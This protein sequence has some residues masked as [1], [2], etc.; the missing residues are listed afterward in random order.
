VDATQLVRLLAE[1]RAGTVTPEEAAQRIGALPYA[2]V[3]Q[4]V[5]LDH[6]RELRTGIPEMVYGAS[7]TADQIV[8]AM[9]ELVKDGGAIATRVDAAKAA[10][11][12]AALPAA[13]YHEGARVIVLGKPG[14]RPPCATIAV[15]CAGTSDLG[16][17]EECGLVA[18]FLGA[19][20]LRVG[21][22]GVAGLHRLLAR[23]ED[24]RR[25][26][27]VVGVA[28]ME[29]ALP[30]V[31]G[32]LIDKPL[33]AVPT[34]VGYGVSLDGLVALGALLSG[35]VPGT[36]VVNIDN[37]VGAAVAAVKIGRLATR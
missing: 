8:A 35:C 2:E 19:P 18:E 1:V 13:V 10:A 33:I 26:D 30:S 14:P 34:S 27:V 17:A 22:V 31:L 20:V 21:D 37:G 3:A 29:A 11:V 4:A 5:V 28:G 9:R 16:V 7:K 24:I 15:V 12:L 23:I 6:H 25:C 32:G 36:T